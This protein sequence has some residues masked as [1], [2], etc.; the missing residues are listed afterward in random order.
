M[1]GVGVPRVTDF[2]LARLLEEDSALTQANR[3]AGTPPYLAPEQARG[4]R[5]V[6]TACADVYAL[7]AILYELLTGRPPFV[8]GS[9]M[10]AVALVGAAVP[11]VATWYSGQLRVEI[12]ARRRVAAD[13]ERDRAGAAAAEFATTLERVRQ[14]RLARPPG[15]ASSNLADLRGVAGSPLAAGFRPE[16]RT[17]AAAALSGIDPG[18]PRVLLPGFQ[19]YAPAFRPDGA[20]VALGGW[21]PDAGTCRVEVADP[22]TGARLRTLTYPTDPR[23]EGRYGKPNIDGRRSLAF[24]PDGRWLVVGTRRGWLVRWDLAAEPPR[25][26]RWR[27]GPPRDDPRDDRGVR[28]AFTPDGRTLVS[29]D[30]VRVAGW[31]AGRDWS[32]AFV[33]GTPVENATIVRP[34]RDGDGLFVATEEKLYAVGGDPPAAHPIGQLPTRVEA[35]TLDGLGVGYLQGFSTLATFGVGSGQRMTPVTQQ[36]R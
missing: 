36:G 26:V 35:A 10:A 8:G 16:L 18:P 22:A 9:D 17:E 15:W 24:S 33:V 12:E 13:A 11:V 23:W 19:A 4:E 28:L 20:A 7:G 21:L 1:P 31:D 25:P 29:T 5:R 30:A 34:A 2:G 27:H 6:L 3:V 32:G 14:R